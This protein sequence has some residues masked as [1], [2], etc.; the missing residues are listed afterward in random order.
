MRPRRKNLTDEELSK[1]K[2]LESEGKTRL[3]IAAEMQCTP[4]CVTRRLGTIR[5]H[6][7]IEEPQPA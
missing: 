4:S 6:K 1:M 3:E 5:P 2:Q 7:K